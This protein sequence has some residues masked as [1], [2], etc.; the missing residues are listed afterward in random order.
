MFTFFIIWKIVFTQQDLHIVNII[1]NVL[2]HICFTLEL[3]TLQKSLK[4]RDN[5]C[6]CN[7]NTSYRLLIKVN[8]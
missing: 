4:V 7:C 6:H 1:L 3:S 5:M 2:N 8:I